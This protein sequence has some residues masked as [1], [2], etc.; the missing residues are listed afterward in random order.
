MINKNKTLSDFCC[1]GCSS[2]CSCSESEKPKKTYPK[3]S[4]SAS[5]CKSTSTSTKPSTKIPFHVAVVLDGNRRFA[6]TFGL[7]TSTGHFAGAMK[8]FDISDWLFSRGV[9]TASYYAWAIKNFSRSEEE[10]RM[11]YAFFKFLPIVVKDTKTDLIKKHGILFKIA[12]NPDLFP[13]EVRIA[14]KQ[15][16]FI[17]ARILK[18]NKIKH[19]HTIN[20]CVAYGFEDELYRATINAVKK[21]GSL[22]SIDDIFSELDVRVPVDLFIRPGKEVRDS[23]FLPI[24]S[25]Q[26]EKV[27]YPKL[28]PEFTEEDIDRI[29]SE[30]SNR[31]RRFGGGEGHALPCISEQLLNDLDGLCLSDVVRLGKKLCKCNVSSLLMD[32]K[33]YLDRLFCSTIF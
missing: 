23:G 12:G 15:V 29:L 33:T 2:G 3:Y 13:I 4:K 21:K 28:L 11:L 18:E 30:Y 19:R 22:K 5:S 31:E 26:A 16:E 8:M 6:K 32:A 14:F 24:Q 1:S 27:Y 25:A 10:K 20:I 17:S 9:K 7:P